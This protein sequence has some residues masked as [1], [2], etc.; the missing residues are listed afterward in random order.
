M[1]L[2]RPVGAQLS[3]GEEPLDGDR[4]PPIVMAGSEPVPVYA[5]Y[6]KKVKAAEQVEPLSSEL[7]G[8]KVSLYTG[9]T[10][11]SV[12]DIDLPGNDALPVQLRRRFA[13]SL[14]SEGQFWD[15]L[16]SPGSPYG[17]IGNWDVEVPYIAGVFDSQY[18]W[19]RPDWSPTTLPRCST[20]FMPSASQPGLSATDVWSG[21]KVHIPGLGDKSLLKR[22]ASATPQPSYPSAQGWVT[23]DF[24][25]FTCIATAN[26]HGEGFVMTTTEGISYKFDWY[27]ERGYPAVSTGASSNPRVM[28]FLLAS[29]VSDRFGNWVKYQY[30]GD[31]HPEK[32]WSSDG[33]QIDLVYDLA[34]S[35]ILKPSLLQSAKI[36]LAQPPQTRTW[37]YAYEVSPR[38]GSRLLKTVTQPDGSQW[39]YT[40]ANDLYIRYVAPDPSGK[41]CLESTTDG[42]GGNYTLT[43]EHPAG[44]K[45]EFNFTYGRQR[46]N[47]RNNDCSNGRLSYTDYIDGFA[48][49]TK[50]IYHTS[51]SSDRWQYAYGTDFCPGCSSVKTQVTQP[52][53][54]VIEYEF[55]SLHS[56]TYYSGVTEGRL[57][58]TRYRA[59][60]NGTVLRS[61]QS[62]YV[63]GQDTSGGP[64]TGYLFP[65]R[66]GTVWGGDDGSAG[67]L[68]PLMSVTTTQQDATFTRNHTAFDT[69]GRPTTTVKSSSLGHSRTE[70]TT[71]AQDNTY[72]WVLGQIESVMETGTDQ[73]IVNNTY[74]PTWATLLSVKDYGRLVRSMT[75]RT[76]GDGTL[77]TVKDGA[78]KTTTLGTFK[79]GIPT[80]VT[81]ADGTAQSA[82]IDD[83]GSIRSVTDETGAMTTYDYDPMG[84][85]KTITPPCCDSVAWNTTSILYEQTTATEEGMSGPH[86]RQ[87]TTTGNA[88]KVVVYDGRWRPV[89]TTEYDTADVSGTVRKIMRRYDHANRETYASYPYRDAVS[90]GD[91]PG[92]NTTYDALGRVTKVRQYTGST[93]ADT[94]T[95]Y[96]TGFM[97]RVTDPRAQVTT[98]SFQAFDAPSEDAPTTIT[99]PEGVT[100]TID[101]DRFGKPRSVTRSGLYNGSAVSQVRRYYYDSNLQLCATVEPESGTTVQDYDAAGNLSWIAKGT[102]Q[103]YCNRAGVAASDKTEFGYDLRNRLTSVTYPGFTSPVSQ[104]WYADG[105][106]KTATTNGATW[107]YTYNKRRLLESESLAYDGQ[108]FQIDRLYDAN[109]ALRQLIYPD[110]SSIDYAPNALGQPTQAGSYAISAKYFPNGAMSGF[111]YGNGIVHSLTQ[112]GRQLPWQSKDGTV[113]DLTYTYDANANVATI[114]DG[115]QSGLENRTLGYDGLNRLTSALAP[116]MWGTASFT[117]DPLD[118]LRVSAVGTRSCTHNLNGANQLGSLSGSNC[119]TT[120]YG[121]DGRGNV[122]QRGSQVFTFDRADRMT[123]ATGKESYTYDAHGRRVRVLHTNDNSKLYQVYSKDGQ[124][125]YGLDTATGKAT[126]YVYLNGSLVAR[127]EGVPGAPFLD[128]PDPLTSS[129]NPSADGSYTL[130]WRAVSGATSYV[131]KQ[132]ANLGAETTIYSG[133]A[134]SWSVSGVP[135]GSYVYRVQACAGS[136]CSQFSASL[137]Q[138]VQSGVSVVSVSPSPSTNGAYTVSWTSVAGATRY[139]LKETPAG[140]SEVTAY[141]GS[142][143]SWSASS[144]P[145]GT[146]SYRVQACNGSCGA[147]GPPATAVVA[148]PVP[149]GLQASPSPATE[150]TSYSV[151]WQ[152]V[153]GAVTY[154]V[155]EKPSGGSWSALATSSLTYR[156]IAGHPLGTWSY[157]V[158][159][160]RHATDVAYCGDYATM[161]QTVEEAVP[162]LPTVPTGLFVTPRPSTDGNYTLSWFA[163]TDASYYQVDEKYQYDPSGW[164][165]TI[166][167]PTGTSWSPSPAKSGYGDY[168]YRVRACNSLHQCSASSSEVTAQV[169]LPNVLP[170]QPVVQS[171][172]PSPSTT[173]QYTVTWSASARAER[174]EV[175]EYTGTGN[176]TDVGTT[177]GT[178]TSWSPSPP[179]TVNGTYWYRIRGCN[180]YGCG[181][182]S[183]P[184]APAAVT[185]QL[186]GPVTTPT[187][188]QGP[189]APVQMGWQYTISWDAQTSATRYYLEE[190]GICRSQTYEVL[191]SSIQIEGFVPTNC[192]NWEEYTYRVKACN[193]TTCSGWSSSIRVRVEKVLTRAAGAATT[194]VHTDGLRSPV[195]ETNASGLVTSRMRY[196]PYGA[197]LMPPAQGPGYTGHVTDAATGLSYMQQRYYDPMAGRFLSVDPIAAS[198]ASFNRYW[199]ANNNPYKFID[200]DGRCPKNVGS[201]L[202]VESTV[203]LKGDRADVKLDAQGEKYAV[204]LS[205]TSSVDSRGETEERLKAVVDS[206]GKLV[207]R[208]MKNTKKQESNAGHSAQGDPP[209]GTQFVMHGHV[210]PTMVDQPGLGDSQA[211]LDVGLPNVAVTGENRARV[212]VREIEGGKL[213]HRM[214]RGTMSSSEVEA[215]QRHMDQAAGIYNDR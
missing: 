107:T 129:K 38:D 208:G 213:Q 172:S 92:T 193:G 29:Q 34:N 122:V 125:L 63:T 153:A 23:T 112:N 49:T 144:K 147:F 90:K 139:V 202:C 128:A 16:G 164:R 14:L 146:Y 205:G 209:E 198:P 83:A 57:L 141:D 95:E 126:S 60:A 207:S 157:Q 91:P 89:M 51:T 170:S 99:L 177:P 183:P 43:I 73:P 173:G 79:R 66:Y 37:T 48:L 62:T 86:W 15:Y 169:R 20:P 201:N 44:A 161:N 158:R 67:S 180:L 32:I 17:G 50:R 109:A 167:S 103:T 76:P 52:D 10:E 176:Y 188:L 195:A 136:T 121:Y 93:P 56:A 134:T 152:A 145:D 24:D 154:R 5:E 187:G 13:V 2:P 160:C 28:V 45:G 39:T 133:S 19:D 65:A 8:D 132:Q 197:T 97:K 155:D 194:Y 212:G 162:G 123:A 124:L 117:Y 25:R 113:T 163:S 71:Y 199:Y 42:Q 110:E 1:A 166:A 46:R 142:A 96:L 7:F 215:I 108:S 151:S 64:L 200:P 168:T 119:P 82:V 40:P 58:A 204:S 75:Y 214:L 72:Y 104:T 143:L 211:P 21:H 210:N 22:D 70:S 165:S 77:L 84:R 115:A 18:K 47:V 88:K 68:R 101:R 174:H 148:T 127:N 54:G 130:T 102:T 85:V 206:K 4:S 35:G 192:G 100:V 59:T 98:T 94:T 159:A 171:I 31:G 41:E 203:K 87:T 149:T 184:L 27:L 11:F 3:V 106:L 182:Y 78:N 36:T 131:L 55:S 135:N 179:K 118:N 74:D 138:V 30:N 181:D 12:V 114:T 33:R 189:N 53:S 6:S 156:T 81:Y 196:E 105:A 185:V 190:A 61:E 26:G 191:I 178:T 175:Q 150:Y 9:Q 137:T 116:S 111:T 186:P 120:S 80:S 140:G 69:Y